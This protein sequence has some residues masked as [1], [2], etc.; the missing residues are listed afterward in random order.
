MIKIDKEK[1]AGC[2]LCESLCSEGLQMI[3]GK[4]KIKNENANCISEVISACR[5]NAISIKK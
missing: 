3:D 4:A 2:G 1:C 5:V